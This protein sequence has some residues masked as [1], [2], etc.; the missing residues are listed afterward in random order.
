[1]NGDGDSSHHEDEVTADICTVIDP[2]KVIQQIPKRQAA[3]QARE[4][5]KVLKNKDL[6]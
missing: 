4:H 6:I 1:M 2:T 5:L 3:L